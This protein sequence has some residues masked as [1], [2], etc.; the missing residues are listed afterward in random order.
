MAAAGRPTLARPTFRRCGRAVRGLEGNGPRDACRH[1][2]KR[3][4]AQ[5]ERHVRRHTRLAEHWDSDTTDPHEHRR[6]CDQEPDRRSRPANLAAIAPHH[7]MSESPRDETARH[8]QHRYHAAHDREQHRN[9]CEPVGDKAPERLATGG[10]ICGQVCGLG[11]QLLNLRRDDGGGTSELVGRDRRIAHG[12]LRRRSSHSEERFD[13]RRLSVPEL[14][15]RELRPKVRSHIL[16]RRGALLSSLE[17][18]IGT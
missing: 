13:L 5:D 14:V 18:G 6:P 10:D 4:T 15:A 11:C 9:G 2:E 1:Q 7:R 17:L 8:G 3:E 16:L 12:D